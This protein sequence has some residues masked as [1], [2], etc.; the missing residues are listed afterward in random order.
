MNSQHNGSCFENFNAL[1]IQKKW[2]F[3]KLLIPDVINN[4]SPG[5]YMEA[6]PP[7]KDNE[8][9]YILM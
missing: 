9:S 1:C 2:R 4:H 6:T 8:T 3:F 7:S 5:T